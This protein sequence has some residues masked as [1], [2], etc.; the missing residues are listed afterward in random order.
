MGNSDAAAADRDKD[1]AMKGSGVRE[2]GWDLARSGCCWGD[3]T[4]K[5]WERGIAHCSKRH[6]IR[7]KTSLVFYFGNGMVV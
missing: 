7:W 6:K 3:D 1:M 2:S 5:G 4:H